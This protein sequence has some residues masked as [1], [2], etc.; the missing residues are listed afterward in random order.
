MA[1]KRIGSYQVLED[2][3]SGGQATVYRAWDTRTGQVIALKV[4][5][6]HLV[7][8]ATYLERFQREARLAASINHPNV[9]RIFDVGQD[10]ESHFMALEFLPLSLNNLVEAQGQM[11]LDRVVD[12]AHQIALG[13]D[14]AHQRGIV[15]RDIKPHNILISPEG[16]AKVTD[17]GIGRAADLSTMTRTGAVMG[18]PHYMAPEQARGMRVDIRSDIY[19]LGIAIYQML[20]G[21][22]PFNAET[23]WEVI[24]QHIEAKPP[25]LRRGR[26][27]VPRALESVVERCLEKDPARRYQTP[28]EMAVALA[29]VMPGVVSAPA[30]P[31]TPSTPPP[32][33]AVSTPPPPPAPPPPPQAA[34]AAPAPPMSPGTTW[35]QQ[36]AKA[37]QK[38]NRRRFAWLG[39]V[40]TLTLGLAITGARLGALDEVRGFIDFT[41]LFGGAEVEAPTVT[42]PEPGPTVIGDITT[43]VSWEIGL[44][45]LPFPVAFGPLGTDN[46]YVWSEDGT[47]HHLN[48]HD[49]GTRWRQQIDEPITG[50]ATGPEGS[51]YTGLANGVLL[52]FTVDGSKKFEVL[53][54]EDEDV[55]P[56]IGPSDE[57]YAA[58]HDGALS[59]VSPEDGAILWKIPVGL[60]IEAPP[61]VG[62]EGIVYV[63][64]VD[65]GS[66]HA[67]S[68]EGEELW[69]FE[70][71]PVTVSPAVGSLYV[72]TDDDI[73]Y[74]FVNE[75][76]RRA[77]VMW[78]QD[79]ESVAPPAI[80]SDGSVYVLG[81]KALF[82]FSPDDGSRQLVTEQFVDDGR[83]VGFVLGQGDDMAYVLTEAGNVWGVDTDGNAQKLYYK[84]DATWLR[85]GPENILYLGGD[86][87]VEALKVAPSEPV[88]T[89]AYFDLNW[90]HS[91]DLLD[92]FNDYDH[93][94]A[95]EI[96]GR[97]A[98]GVN[99]KRGAFQ[100][101]SSY[102]WWA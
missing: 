87:S 98:G 4:M 46:F 9:V 39:T 17:F 16:T 84:P 5:H 50:A 7:R 33:P 93:K 83:A 6:P 80:A 41:G 37:W 8:D 25:Q 88:V 71:G 60:H 79:V 11:P 95:D 48:G 36:W 86:R 69:S 43:E 59:R 74:A 75:R 2:I 96:K 14:S 54:S 10:G 81:P 55:F 32:T 38:S 52:G 30:Q 53:L 101:T 21:E 18:T 64:T 22:L 85:Q 89:T 66:I 77:R 100:A 68:P 102:H 67:F 1:Q 3:A 47:L 58:T 49:G 78:T 12:I 57:L 62:P 51:L 28:S 94:L 97:T 13:L 76:N 45:G 82:K 44:R 24:R 35:M 91:K 19:S 92:Q 70:T 72:A 34:P 15:H 27:D 29:Q 90:M 63:G 99:F 26:P 31:Q 56:A 65:P 40:I 23:P 20:T 42:E 61:V 73:L